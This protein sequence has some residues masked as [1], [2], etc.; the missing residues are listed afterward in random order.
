MPGFTKTQNPVLGKM[1]SSKLNKR[2]LKIM[3]LV[4]RYSWGYHKTYAQL[5]KADYGVAGI[6]P[7]V[8]TDELRKLVSLKVIGWNPDRDIV[9]DW[10]FSNLLNS[11]VGQ[12]T[13]GQAASE[14]FARIRALE[15]IPDIAAGISSGE[16]DATKLW[17]FRQSG[18]ARNSREWLD[19]YGPEN[20]DQLI[21]KYA[22]ALRGSGLISS[23]PS[24]TIRI[25]IVNAATIGAAIVA[26][27]TV[28][29]A[30]MGLS[31]A[32]SF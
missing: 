23:A 30:S 1:F 9:T 26:P 7:A 28:W 29:L 17:E 21:Q 20:P 11:R 25:L 5:T 24:Q 27:P 2:Q 8:V 15:G 3:L 4:I 18:T 14:S 10:G 13:S 12:A 32:D 16:I 31:T 22:D 6:G 19:E